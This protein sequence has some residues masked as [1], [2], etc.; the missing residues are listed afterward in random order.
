MIKFVLDNVGTADIK[1][2]LIRCNLLRYIYVHI[3]QQNIVT[4]DFLGE[5]LCTACGILVLPPGIKPRPSTVKA[6][7][8]NHWTTKKFLQLIYICIQIYIRGR[9]QRGEKISK[10]I[11]VK[12]FLNFVKDINLQIQEA[13]RTPSSINSKETTS[14]YINDQL[15]KTTEKKKKKLKSRSSQ[16]LHTEVRSTTDFSLGMKG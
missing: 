6:Q 11:M 16:R 15:L 3:S 12:Y 4:V 1:C 7:S 9:R 14:R 8:P 2:I 13:Q 5:P 10:E